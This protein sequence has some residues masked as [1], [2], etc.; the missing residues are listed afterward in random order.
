MMRIDMNEFD[1][2]A[3]LFS[4][5]F[6]MVRQ[7]RT[8]SKNTCLGENDAI[9]TRIA[10]QSKTGRAVSTQR[11]ARLWLDRI[12][13][14]IGTAM[15][16][17]DE[18]GA[19]RALD[20]HD[21]EPRMLKLMRNYYGGMSLSTGAAPAQIRGN[22]QRYFGGELDALGA[23]AWAT[24]GTPF[25]QIVWNALVGIP[26]GQTLSYGELARRLGK[27]GASRAVGLANGS[28]P[29]ALVVPC[30]R[31]IGANGT[32]TGYGGGLHR[33]HWLLRH[34]GA[35]FIEDANLDLFNQ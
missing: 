22:L 8:E 25:Q 30:H 4:E 28:N 1:G 7:Y 15:L 6:S 18:S 14:P 33:K 2:T 13:T 31:V 5:D 23:I 9:T 27:P 16:V 29:V 34:E 26:C 32:L 35:Q 24:A 20:F 17:T 21:Y 12:A 19:L 11:P 10:P 3:G